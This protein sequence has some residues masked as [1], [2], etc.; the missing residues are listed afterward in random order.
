VRVDGVPNQLLK[1]IG[2][3]VGPVPQTAG[4]TACALDVQETAQ[5]TRASAELELVHLTAFT[6]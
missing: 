3:C 5:D 6:M 4:R 2:C 1:H